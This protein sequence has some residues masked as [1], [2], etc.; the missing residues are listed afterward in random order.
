MCCGY[1][2]ETRAALL[3]NM[4][5]VSYT[6]VILCEQVTIRLFNSQVVFPIKRKTSDTAKIK[7]YEE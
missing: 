4:Y 7:N 5:A 3:Y 6:Y 1:N 2:D